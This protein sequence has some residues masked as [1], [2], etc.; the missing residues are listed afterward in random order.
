MESIQ[1]SG[2]LIDGKYKIIKKIGSGAFG[3]IYKG[4]LRL[5]SYHIS[6]GHDQ[7]RRS[8]CQIRAN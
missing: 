2:S 8:S 1:A 7:E 5:T 6:S 3:I 4:N